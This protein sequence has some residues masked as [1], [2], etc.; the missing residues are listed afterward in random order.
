MLRQLLR[1]T[2]QTAVPPA[3]AT[4]SIVI[5]TQVLSLVKAMDLGS[6]I[7]LPFD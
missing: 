2:P 1:F 5:Y 7:C 4:L 6:G 3:F